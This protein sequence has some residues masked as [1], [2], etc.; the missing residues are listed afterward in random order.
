MSLMNSL[1]KKIGRSLQN[2][3][4]LLSQT[5]SCEEGG[6]LQRV[7]ASSTAPGKIG[8]RTQKKKD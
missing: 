1:R 4:L 2:Y 7:A 6:T 3:P 8:N 5:L